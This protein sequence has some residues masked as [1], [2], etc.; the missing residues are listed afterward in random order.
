MILPKLFILCVFMIFGQIS[1]AHGE[2]KAGPN[3]GFIRMPGA[4]HTELIPQSKN[5]LKIYLLDLQWKNPSV[6]KSKIEIIYNEKENAKCEP[7]KNF[8]ICTF[9]KSVDLRKKG[10]LKVSAEREEQKGTEVSYS[11]PFKLKGTDVD[12]NAHH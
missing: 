10:A 12:H 3:G 2:D 9:S 7:E 11:L 6:T 4:F 5:S 8:F 1:H